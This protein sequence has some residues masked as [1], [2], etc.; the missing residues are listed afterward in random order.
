MPTQD[1]GA[2]G[3]EPSAAWM[4]E[5]LLYD[6]FDALAVLV[7][8]IDR[9]EI[10]RFANRIHEEWFGQPRENLAGKHLRE[11]IGEAAYLTIKSD[12][13]AAL[14]G[15]AFAC[16]KTVPY[17]SCGP[18]HVQI[19][20]TPHRGEN[21]EIIGLYTRTSDLS[22][23]K[24]AEDKLY[25]SQ[26]RLQSVLATTPDGIITIDNRGIIESFS[27][28]AE[29]LFGYYAV[30]VIGENVKMLMPSPY[31]EE[32]DQY[33]S[34]YFET[35]E[36]KIIGKG[37][38]VTARRKDGSTFPINLAVDEIILDGARM[39]TGIIHDITDEVAR[40]EELRHAQKMEAVG[41]LTGGVAHD[42]NNLLTVIIGNLEML[43][44]R[45]V[46]DKLAGVLLEQAQE[47]ADL[48]AQL[49]SRMLA[50]ARRQPLAPK[51]I[52]LSELVTETTGLL[53]RSLGESIEITSVL[54]S[55]LERTLADPSQLQNALLN[56][57][58]NARDAMPSGGYLTIETTNTELDED[59]AHA[60]P[61]VAPGRYVMLSV[62]DTGT[63]IPLDI[64]SRVFEPF[65]TTKDVGSG[66]GLGLSMIYGFAKQ[67]GGHLRLYSE[68]G[69]GTTVSLYLPQNGGAAASA[70]KQLGSP[71]ESGQQGVTVL[72]VEDDHRVRATT[73]ARVKELGYTVLEASDG[74]TAL[75][76]LK[77]SPA[78]DVLFT[79]IVMPGGMMGNELAQEARRLYP[80][81]KVLFTSGYTEQ[82]SV[83][84][85]TMEE[86]GAL[87]TKP[88]RRADLASKLREVIDG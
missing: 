33:L 76:V 75:E 38:Q 40:Q 53:Q 87:L 54:A 71:K 59:Y 10:L 15:E 21:Q 64:Q 28:S 56:L 39:F 61:D 78:V 51:I 4:S 69:V 50:F 70:D 58:L 3:R 26:A 5:R 57:C 20:F 25:A 17:Q 63:G 11:V 2:A 19:L 42:F 30:E 74:A 13:D 6:V 80:N 44:P 72:V 68:M 32:H 62:S 85:G 55:D 88:Y 12:I 83:Q 35:G 77:Q 27:P 29:R 41:Q 7:S 49:T 82:A 45:V 37:R 1:A 24:A 73:I 31:R 48:G 60:H 84:A 46:D 66:S 43:E 34:N 36:K 16:E 86:G 65:F 18:R 8:Y 67:S 23:R 14:S 47:A 22:A 52:D 81:I 79:D 9:D